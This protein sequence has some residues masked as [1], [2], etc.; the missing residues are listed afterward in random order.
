MILLHGLMHF[1][2]NRQ[3]DD[4]SHGWPYLHAVLRRLPKSV[5]QFTVSLIL[6]SDPKNRYRNAFKNS[7]SGN[8]QWTLIRVE[9]REFASLRSLTFVVEDT[10]STHVMNDH[11]RGSRKLSSPS[12]WLWI[13]SVCYTWR[14]SLADVIGKFLYVR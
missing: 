2:D 4:F 7:R 3:V 6:M 1:V 13:G 14:I 11:L 8:A 10:T 5:E 12:L 9:L